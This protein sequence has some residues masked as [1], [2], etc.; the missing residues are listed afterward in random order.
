MALPPGRVV[1]HRG[2]LHDR[3]SWLT[4]N[5]V[6]RDDERGLLFWRGAGGPHLTRVAVDGRSLR[7]VP[8]A[9]WAALRT[10]IA[11]GRWQRS[12]VL[13]LVPTDTAHSVWWFFR[14]GRFTSWYVN[15]EAPAV[16]WD[17]GDACG[18]DF[19][20]HDLDIVVE[21]DRSWRWKDEDELAERSRYPE[22]YW[23][24]DPEAV[25]AEGRRLVPR[26]EAGQFPFDG[27]WCD[28]TP[29]PA[30]SEPATLPAGWDRPRARLGGSVP[31]E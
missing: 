16:R 4:V 24:P 25:W 31:P 9:E 17:D 19:T 12:S 14:G 11:H 18:L 20:D 10:R 21:P 6:V 23:V 8:F 13:T 27:T 28:F 30:W 15:L 22:H 5:R 29:D 3:L 2:F 7:E 1:L 26:I